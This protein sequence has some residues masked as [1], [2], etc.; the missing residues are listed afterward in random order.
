MI[1]YVNVG[2]NQFSEASA[3]YDELLGSIGASRIFEL[4]SFIVWST[5]GSAPALSL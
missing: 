1:G 5:S 3:F 4:E 2:T